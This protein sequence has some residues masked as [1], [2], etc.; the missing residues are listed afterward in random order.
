MIIRRQHHAHVRGLP[1]YL[2]P[3]ELDDQLS[4]TALDDDFEA[5]LKADR[6]HVLQGIG[7]VLPEGDER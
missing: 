1:P 2:N 6:V 7:I 4:E 3:I 5:E